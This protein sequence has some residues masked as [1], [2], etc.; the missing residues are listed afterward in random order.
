[1]GVNVI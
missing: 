1:V